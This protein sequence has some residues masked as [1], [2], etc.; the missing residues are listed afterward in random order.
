[1]SSG[2]G[3]KNLQDDVKACDKCLGVV[4]GDAPQCTGAPYSPAS[5]HTMIAMCCATNHHP[6][7][8]VL[9]EDY[10][11]EVEMLQPGTIL[12]LPQTVSHDIKVIYAKM[13]K[14]VCTLSFGLTVKRF[15]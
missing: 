1:M 4:S 12:P 11:A 5:H 6:F 13:S 8:S 2:H 9:D 3:T 10:Q 7:N 15:H 14:N